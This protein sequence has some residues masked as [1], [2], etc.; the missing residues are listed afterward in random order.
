[1]HS[2]SLSLSDTHTH[3]QEDADAADMHIDL[4]RNIEQAIADSATTLFCCP[5]SSTPPSTPHSGA[6]GVA[7]LSI[8]SSLREAWRQMSQE[9][10]LF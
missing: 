8:E 5:P 3:T 9:V 2:V 6:P 7:P 4:V 1:M 10:C